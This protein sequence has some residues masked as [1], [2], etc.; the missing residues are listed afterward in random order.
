M[1]LALAPH[2]ATTRH[3]ASCYLFQADPPIE[4]GP[5][6]RTRRSLGRDVLLRPLRRLRRGSHHESE[7]PRPRRGGKRQVDD[8]EAALLD[9]TGAARAIGRDL[10]PEGRVRAAR[11][12]A[13]SADGATHA[14]RTDTD[15][16]ARA[17]RAGHPRRAPP[18]AP[19]RRRRARRVGARTTTSPRGTRVSRRDDR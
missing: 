9:R 1:T 13:R 2:R 4:V 6:P 5:D 17:R 12:A 14:G 8:R 16:S 3:L 7:P 10:G 15:Q 18:P 11:S 19:R